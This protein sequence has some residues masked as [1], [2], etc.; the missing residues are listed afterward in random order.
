M[1]E[2]CYP[3]NLECVVDVAELCGGAA[4]TSQLFIRRY[5]RSGARAG[6]NI[7]FVCGIDLMDET[8]RQW[9]WSYFQCCK[10]F[11]VI[12][13]TPCTGMAGWKHINRKINYATY[14]ENRRVSESLADFGAEV[15]LL[16]LKEERHFFDE[17][18]ENSDKF[19]RPSWKRVLASKKVRQSTFH[20]CQLGLVGSK[21]GLPVKK[22]TVVTASDA[23]LVSP[24]DKLC[25]VGRNKCIEHE[26]VEGG[27]SRQTAVWPWSMASL[28]ADNVAGLLMRTMKQIRSYHFSERAYQL[29]TLDSPSD[30]FAV[31]SV[32]Q[33]SRMKSFTEMVV[34]LSEDATDKASAEA[35]NMLIEEEDPFLDP[36]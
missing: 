2:W 29:S 17:H 11:V 6:L 31:S 10:P 30:Q 24:F 18:P 35:R 16:Q 15:A 23:S 28:V 19:D 33:R 4:R 9:A 14:S 3:A 1:C 26:R 20:Q 34:V 8:E 32:P 22:A 27:N 36:P 13:S 12:I 7:D 5:H 25:C 21:T